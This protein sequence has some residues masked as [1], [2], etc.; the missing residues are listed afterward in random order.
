MNKTENR[1]MIE[2]MDPKV[3]SWKRSMK[4]TN[5][6]LWAYAVYVGQKFIDSELQKK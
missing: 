2:S 6:I 5:E 1:K 3:D 4:L